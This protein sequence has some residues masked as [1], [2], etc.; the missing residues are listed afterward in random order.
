MRNDFACFMKRIFFLLILVSVTSRLVLGQNYQTQTLYIYSFGKFIQWPEENRTGDFEI[1]VLGDSPIIAE[2]QKM[3]EKK[4][5]GDRTIKINKVGSIKE[6]RKGHVLFIPA[7]QSALLSE[8]LSKIGTQP[9]LIVTE[10]TGLGTKGS[11][12]NFLLKE[13]RL[14]FELNQNALTKHKLKAANE[15]TRLAILI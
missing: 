8:C 6:F 2:L 5:I 3:A 14:V 13:D 7:A 1:T 9:T 11:D 4:K 15:L 10:Q 12:V